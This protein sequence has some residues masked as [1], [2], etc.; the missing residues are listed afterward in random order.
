[1]KVAEMNTEFFYKKFEVLFGEEQ[2]A[3]F[4]EQERK[5]LYVEFCLGF[6]LVELGMCSKHI[7]QGVCTKLECAICNNLCTGP[8]YLEQ[9][10]KMYDEQQDL[11]NAML[12][13]YRQN[14]NS[15]YEHYHEYQRVLRLHDSYKDVIERIGKGEYENETGS[16]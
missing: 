15:G 5:Q 14:N 16:H 3:R 7:S 10:N 11:L 13:V 6:R 8:A 1:M 12:E 2:L 4:D 9:W